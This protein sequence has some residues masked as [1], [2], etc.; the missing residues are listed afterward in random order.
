MESHFYHWEPEL[1]TRAQ[2]IRQYLNGIL[3]REEEARQELKK[4][5]PPNVELLKLA[6]RHTAPQEWHDE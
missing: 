5:T 6:D 4:I 1:M 2:E 3:D